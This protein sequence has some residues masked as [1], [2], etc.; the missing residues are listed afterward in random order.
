MDSD[1]MTPAQQAAKVAARLG[2]DFTKTVLEHLEENCYI[3]S[4]PDCFI[5]ACDTYREFG[6]SAPEEAVFIALAVGNLDHFLEIDPRKE[7]RKW[8]GFCR[9][10]QGQVHWLPYQ[11][12]RKKACSH[13]QK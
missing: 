4:S 8:L 13:S 5:L 10:D 9:E 12:L 6:E 3:Y 7:T 11:E 1:T 2:M